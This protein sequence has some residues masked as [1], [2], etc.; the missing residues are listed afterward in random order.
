MIMPKTANLNIRI[1]PKVKSAAEELFGSFGITV[2]DAVNI[3]LHQS[4]N[5]GGLPFSLRAPRYRP[6]AEAAMLEALDISGGKI[7][8]KSYSS[9]RE[10]F[11]EL[12]AEMETEGE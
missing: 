9:A 12:D 7:P 5:V 1:D 4:L 3:F 10:L 6:E 11:A 2:T 8:A